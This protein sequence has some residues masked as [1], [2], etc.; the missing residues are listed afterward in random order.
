MTSTN[1]TIFL[2]LFA[3][4]ICVLA[5]A[6]EMAFAQT[7][8]SQGSARLKND[9]IAILTPIIGLGLV[10]LGVMCFFGKVNWMWFVGAIFGTILVF[11]HEQIINWFRSAFGV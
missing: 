5:F 7:S 1:R 2:C 4:L 3:A 6:P 10:A 11:G 9:F 8:F